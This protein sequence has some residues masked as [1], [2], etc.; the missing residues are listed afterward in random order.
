MGSSLFDGAM[1]NTKEEIKILRQGGW[2][3][4]WNWTKQPL[5]WQCHC[6]IDR[7]EYHWVDWYLKTTVL[8][9][10]PKIS[11]GM[12]YIMWYTQHQMEEKTWWIW[13]LIRPDAILS[14]EMFGIYEYL[15]LPPAPHTSHLLTTNP[16]RL[17]LDSCLLQLT[18]G[19]TKTE[20]N[21]NS[22]T[23]S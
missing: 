11:A 19:S 1:N 7:T 22:A 14:G 23:L 6:D 5:L 21:Q 17:Y 18:E 15:W 10:Y 8:D 20:S 4:W 13:N 12:F 2:R 16:N 3:Q 9:W